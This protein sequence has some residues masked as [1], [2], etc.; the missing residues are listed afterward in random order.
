M[1]VNSLKIKWYNN[2]N[3]RYKNKILIFI[4]PNVKKNERQLNT[5]LSDFLNKSNLKWF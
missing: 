2:D 1:I 3:K 5:Q 4:L